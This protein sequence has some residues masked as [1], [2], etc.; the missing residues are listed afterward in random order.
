MRTTRFFTFLTTLVLTLSAYAYD[1]QSGDLYYDIT[2]RGPYDYSETNS[3]EVTYDKLKEFTSVYPSL[4]NAV[5]PK[6]V[7]GPYAYKY[8]DYKVTGIGARAFYYCSSLTSVTIP[9]S[10]TVIRDSAFYKCN[11]LTSITIPSSVYFIGNCAFEECAKLTSVNI[12]AGITSISKQVFYKCSSLTSVT[13]PEGVT[14]IGSLAFKDTALD[15]VTIPESVTSIGIGAFGNTNLT[16]VIIPN[17]VTSIGF[18][19]S[20]AVEF[21]LLL[22]FLEALLVLKATLLKIVLN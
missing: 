3:A 7:K 8:A 6:S 1:F 18:G 22:L 21:L 2:Y 10:V 16:S 19:A 15:S 20:L 14:S 9:E 11:S 4:T 5:I 13:I 17:S 12:P